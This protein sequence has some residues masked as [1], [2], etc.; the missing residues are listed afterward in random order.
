MPTTTPSTLDVRPLPARERHATILS[1]FDALEPGSGFVL[2]NDHDPKPLLYVFQ[3]ERAGRF[4]WSPLEQGPE[5]WRI[6]ISRVAAGTGE[7]AV[8]DYLAWD[9]DRLDGLLATAREAL[10]DGLTDEARTIFGRFRLGLLRHIRM[11]EDVLFPAF[12][13]ATGMPAQAGPTAVMRAEHRDIQTILERMRD[14]IDHP[15]AGLA[16]FEE[17]R[18]ALLLVLGDH[19]EKEEQVVYPVTDQNLMVPGQRDELIRRMQLV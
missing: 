1:T 6:L 14:Q 2:V 9:H 18:Q 5:A 10:G 8:T 16:E 7:R 13:A 12:E 4:D 3:N 17:S 15:L 11:E 19:N